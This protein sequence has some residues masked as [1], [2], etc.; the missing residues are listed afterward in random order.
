MGL[1]DSPL[2]RLAHEMIVVNGRADHGSVSRDGWM[3]RAAL[4]PGRAR[5]P[6]RPL[7]EE[8]SFFQGR[9]WPAN[10]RDRERVRRNAEW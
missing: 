3:E 7:V 10:D 8:V 2:T 6:E 9:A 4:G 5:L 1:G